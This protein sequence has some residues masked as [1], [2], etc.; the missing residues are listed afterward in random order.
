ML[1]LCPFV[2]SFRPITCAAH[3]MLDSLR[4]ISDV[5]LVHDDNVLMDPPADDTVGFCRLVGA[6][7]VTQTGRELGRVRW[8]SSDLG[9]I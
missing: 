1:L 3:V 5:I 7:V 6:V 9:F 4:Q 2:P 8:V